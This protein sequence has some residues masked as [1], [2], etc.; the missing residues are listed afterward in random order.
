MVA[1]SCMHEL[2]ISESKIKLTILLIFLF[3]LIQNIHFLVFYTINFSFMFHLQTCDFSRFP[4][5]S[6]GKLR[7]VFIR[8]QLFLHTERPWGGSLSLRDR[9]NDVERKISCK[10]KRF[11]KETQ[12]TIRRDNWARTF[13]GLY[14]SS[15]FQ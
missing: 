11:E 10:K 15:N 1:R 6:E 14:F 5:N 12:T 4:S 9:E 8:L 2:D 3:I 13:F 7:E